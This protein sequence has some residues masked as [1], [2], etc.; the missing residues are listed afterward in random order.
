MMDAKW[1]IYPP[2]LER[3][4]RQFV[5]YAALLAACLFLSFILLLYVIY[6]GPVGYIAH[7]P[8]TGG[9]PMGWPPG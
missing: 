9:R 2:G 3:W 7:D 4:L 1:Q 5:R 6:F 8:V